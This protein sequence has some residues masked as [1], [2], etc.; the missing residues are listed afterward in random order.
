VPIEFPQAREFMERV[1]ALE[2]PSVI[3]IASHSQEFLEAARGAL[4]AAAGRKHEI[5]DCRLDQGESPPQAAD[6]VVCDTHS[7]RKVKAR[8]VMV[9]PSLSKKSLAALRDAMR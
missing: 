1:R 9:V 5:C 3:V 2:Q 4:A 8:A 6:L 7:R